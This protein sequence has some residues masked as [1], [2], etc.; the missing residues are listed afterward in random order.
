MD[1]KTIYLCGPILSAQ[2]DEANE[3]R[4]DA[5]KHL[6][7]HFTMLDPMRRKF[8]DADMMG[9][10]EIVRFD[11]EDVKAADI[12]LVNFNKIRAETTFC[13]TSMEIREAYLQDKF[14]VVFSGMPEKDISPWL[15][16]HSTRIV[17]NLFE[18]VEYI[19]RHFVE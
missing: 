5:I 17:G 16:Y 18:A 10:N 3:W 11:L 13:G 6:G 14:I 7:S 9:V 1:K 19:R 4:Q 8:N 15:F 12:L 2:D